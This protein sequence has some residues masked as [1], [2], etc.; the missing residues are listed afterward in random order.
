MS[1]A[2]CPDS[3]KAHLPQLFVWGIRFLPC[4]QV[5]QRFEAAG[6]RVFENALLNGMFVAP[7]G[8]R[9]DIGS[10]GGGGGGSGAAA[11]PPAV[12]TS[13]LVLDCM[14]HASPIVR[15]V[16][17]GQKPDGVCLVVGTCARG[18]PENNTGEQGAGG[19]V[20]IVTCWPSAFL[21]CFV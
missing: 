1:N 2:M 8:V 16:R 10:S 14:G 19:G 9:L 12:L 13:R 18:F 7:N 4:L 20:D 11:A 17:F 3:P 15:Q 21:P 5:R 6:G